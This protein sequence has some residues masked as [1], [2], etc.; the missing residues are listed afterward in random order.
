M[1][2]TF[3]L[4][5]RVFM[6]SVGAAGLTV[7]FN[8]VALA[9]EAQSSG[10][11]GAPGQAR[12]RIEGVPK[13][14]GQKI[15]ARDFRARDMAG[16][17]AREQLA[18][19][20]RASV[21]DRVFEGVD[22]SMLPAA[23]QPLRSITQAD[24]ARDAITVPSSATPPPNWPS[25]LL[26]A[27]GARPVFLGQPVAILLFRDFETWRQAKRRL[28]FDPQV[29]KMG[30]PVVVPPVDTPYS[31][32]TYL[33]RYADASGEQFSQVKNGYSNPYA[34]PP[35]PVDVQA[36]EWRERIADTFNQPGVRRFEG[37]YATQ[38][39]DPMFMEPEAGL[40]WLDR[41]GSGS[42][43]L[44]LGTQATNGDL[45]TTL[46]LF[47][48]PGCP[49]KVG[50][51]V[52]N[53]CY[54]GGG[55]GGR[56]VSTFP[57]LL[58]LAAAYA[59]A[60]VR[61]AQDRYEQF[62]SGLKQL[63]ST[64]R[65]RL[66]VTPDGRFLA[67]ESRLQL[68]A[69]GNNNYSQYVAALAGYCGVSGYKVEQAAVDAVALPTPGV[70][71]GS[72]RGFGGPQA[73]FAVECL[74]DEVAAALKI[75]PIVLRERNVLHQGER[76]VTGAPLAQ[77]M[78]LAEICR[79]ART[80]ALWTGR[81]RRKARFEAA[82]LRYGVGFALANQAYGT[83]TDGVMAEVQ[84]AADGKLSVRSNCVDMGNGSATTLAISTAG[85]AGS[86]AHAVHMGEAQYFVDPLGFTSKTRNW[87]D[88]YWTAS[89]SMSSSACLTAFHQ[90]HVTE[91]ATRVLFE[92][93]LL[94]AAARLWGVDA[95]SL[96]GKTRWRGGRLMAPGLPALPLARIAAQVYASGLPAAAMTHAVYRARW[97]TADYSVG[98]WQA[99]LPL[100]GLSTRAAGATVWQR[101]N[102]AN[103]VAPPA[104]ASLYGRSLYAPSGALVALQVDPRNGEVTV[105][106]VHSFLDAGRVLHPDLLAGQ[107]QGGV[108]MGIGQALLEDIP[109]LADGGGSGRWN[110]DRYHVPLAADVPFKRLGLTVLPSTET[111][112]KG[113]AEAVLCPIAPAIANAVADATGVRVRALPITPQKIKE[114]L[115]A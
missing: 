62:Q 91:Q 11:S 35:K 12:W 30:A 42:L 57:P 51:V 107:S 96:R 37:E 59:D 39:L 67:L 14:T 5:R 56:D 77:P 48:A 64:V 115:Q 85:H 50:T 66:A 18:M 9:A 52:L 47:S 7:V 34:K 58:A 60:P 21:V 76:T 90:V 25:S 94:P 113:I 49:I 1:T 83:G 99:A 111:T 80:H 110:L 87:N 54:P 89:F 8:R 71:A 16:W 72:M 20:L 81:A 69:G 68:H 114:A 29:V 26:V 101:H 92:T 65:Q 79:L 61:I 19:I 103:T 98:G 17:P 31:P 53:S 41:S 38:V 45:D 86:N 4:S 102:R 13:V 24:L 100:D 106:Q 33:T 46:K 28:Q 43:N 27:I 44:V 97:V 74:V 22:L 82:G 105:L 109:L 3:E 95:A 55:F 104:D 112:G 40:G 10:W 23:L 2:S 70:V 78:K 108:A 32:A 36:R 93:A 63:D 75:D 88:P 73:S 6:Q 15:Y 84:L